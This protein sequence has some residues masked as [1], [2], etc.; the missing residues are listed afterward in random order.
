MD[1]TTTTISPSGTE[2]T[3]L[4]IALIVMVAAPIIGALAYMIKKIKKSTCCGASM[5]IA[6]TR[7]NTS[8][9]QVTTNEI[10]V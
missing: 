5:E 7:Q 8:D 6:L 2:T 10:S 9:K 1:T 4:Q 3:N